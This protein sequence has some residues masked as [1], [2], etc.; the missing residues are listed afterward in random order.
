MKTF[1]LIALLAFGFY[2]Y[3][4]VGEPSQ[5]DIKGVTLGIPARIEQI[6]AIGVSKV[7]FDH[8]GLH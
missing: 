8:T 6:V 4:S 1:L 5:A 7:E 3:F 2:V